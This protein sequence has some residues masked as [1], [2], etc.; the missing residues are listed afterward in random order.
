MDSILPGAPGTLRPGNDLV[1]RRIRNAQACGCNITTLDT[2][3]KSQ[4]RFCKAFFDSQKRQKASQE[5]IQP[6]SKKP[7]NQRPPEARQ[8]LARYHTHG[9][10]GFKSFAGRGR[11][12]D[13]RE[14]GAR[15]LPGGIESIWETF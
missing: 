11:F 2:L 5:P 14:R 6:A 4:L 7:A 8:K 10:Y 13:G 15:S 3:A 9:V 1:L 12:L